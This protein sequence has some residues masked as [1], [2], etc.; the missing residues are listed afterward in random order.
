MLRAT[1]VGAVLGVALSCAGTGEPPCPSQC[2]GC[3]IDGKCAADCGETF[4]PICNAG[5]CAGCCRDG[6]GT[7]D[8]SRA[9]GGQSCS[10]ACPADAGPDPRCSA[11]N[12]LALLQCRVEL[13]GE[14][15]FQQCARADGGVPTGVDLTGYCPAACDAAGAG[16]LLACAASL[17]GQCA[18]AGTGAPDLLAAQCVPPPDAGTDAACLSTCD[19]ERRACDGRAPLT[20]FAA[21]MDASAQC[22]LTW[23]RCA[24]RCRQ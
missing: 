11:D 22:G 13:E 8:L 15:R 12:C 14:P 23:S 5:N 7:C 4:R 24:Q 10:Y 18:D 6:D 9:C 19:S 1:V 20:S 17:S 21:C 3:C 2:G 16:A